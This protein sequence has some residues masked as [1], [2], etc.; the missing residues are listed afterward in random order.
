MV[1]MK[2]IML[3]IMMVMNAA[4]ITQSALHF[5]NVQYLLNG[6]KNVLY[7]DHSTCSPQGTSVF[8]VF[9][10]EVIICISLVMFSLWLCWLST[11]LFL[12]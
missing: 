9:L 10:R 12:K 5:V 4:T 8:E 3:S 11:V 1:F 7:K 2:F 6:S